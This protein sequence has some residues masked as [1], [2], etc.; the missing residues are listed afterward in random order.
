MYYRFCNKQKN[1]AYDLLVYNIRIKA[2]AA[3][4]SIHKKVCIC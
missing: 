4:I 3:T 1:D 2:I